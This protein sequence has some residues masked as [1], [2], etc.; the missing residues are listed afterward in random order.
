MG[1]NTFQKRE[2][3]NTENPIG[4]RKKIKVLTDNCKGQLVTWFDQEG[5]FGQHHLFSYNTKIIL[6]S[7]CWLNFFS[8]LSNV[9]NHSF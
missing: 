1:E 9:Q 3:I 2:R 5:L 6:H 8:V 7:S 4:G